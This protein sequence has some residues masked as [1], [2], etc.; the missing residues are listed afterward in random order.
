M[1]WS[2]P[3]VVALLVIARTPQAQ[4]QTPAP[5]PPAPGTAAPAVTV[6]PSSAPA[7]A[8]IT[9]P[10]VVRTV[11]PAYPR[12]AMLRRL[13]GDVIVRAVVDTSGRVSDARIAQSLDPEL[14]QEAL[15]AIQQW[16]FAPASANGVPVETAIRAVI[17]FNLRNN[18]RPAFGEWPAGFVASAGRRLAASAEQRVTSGSTTITIPVLDGWEVASDKE[19]GH[20]LL[21]RHP[22]GGVFAIE[23]LQSVSVPITAALPSHEL[24]VVSA[25]IVKALGTA[26][27]KAVGQVDARG[28]TW[29]W[30]DL[31]LDAGTTPP[32]GLF[33]DPKRFAGAHRWAFATT[34]GDRTVV[35]SC[36]VYV[37][38]TANAADSAKPLEQMAADFTEF[39]QRLTIVNP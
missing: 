29:V 38:A 17:T 21:L 19:P 15:R 4:G 30:V 23:P 37:P 36:R 31:D 3:L 24:D 13:E 20:L 18:P 14:D 7:A 16:Q 27:P 8:P 25:A 10:R 33:D 9:A 6:P 35:V 1:P 22:Q 32:A 26:T 39:V 12:S 28:R 34:V 2:V 5:G 11:K